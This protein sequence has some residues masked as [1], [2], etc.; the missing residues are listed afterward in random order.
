MGNVVR[1]FGSQRTGRVPLLPFAYSVLNTGDWLLAPSYT[2][3]IIISHRIDLTVPSKA[4]ES[5]KY[6]GWIS[7]RGFAPAKGKR[8]VSQYFLIFFQIPTATPDR[9]RQ[10]LTSISLR[11]THLTMRS[12]TPLSSEAFIGHQVEDLLGMLGI[13]VLA[14][15]NTFPYS[16]T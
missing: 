7:S 13:T 11:S 8:Q 3:P 15:T 9:Q 16:H 4:H 6:T 2:P 14:L 12:P 1:C 5:I 10:L